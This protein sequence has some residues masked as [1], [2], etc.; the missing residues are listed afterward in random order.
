M[1]KHGLPAVYNAL[2]SGFGEEIGSGDIRYIQD[3]G[4]KLEGTPYL[5]KN[6][7]KLYLCVA[8]TNSTNNDSSFMRFDMKEVFYR[9]NNLYTKAT[10]I[11][12][13]GLGSF[14]SIDVSKYNK[15]RVIHN[16]SNSNMAEQMYPYIHTYDFAVVKN[17]SSVLYLSS[18]YSYLNRTSANASTETYWV[19][20]RIT[21]D[22]ILTA[23]QKGNQDDDMLYIYGLS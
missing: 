8:T 14:G 19:V 4:Q 11:K 6:T 5:D 13:S 20:L 10:L 1:E 23:H 12:N 22:G 15:I 17:E 18:L 9:V 21:K 16:F 3:I 2:M 7:N